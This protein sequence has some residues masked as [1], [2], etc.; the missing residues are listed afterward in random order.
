MIDILINGCLIIL[1]CSFTI[2]SLFKTLNTI[3][4]FRKSSF[5][6]Q[7]KRFKL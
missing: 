5:E 3:R 2:R 1:L 7:I 4:D 6:D